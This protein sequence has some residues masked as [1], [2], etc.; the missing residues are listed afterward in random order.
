[1]LLNLDGLLLP[2][3]LSTIRSVELV[4]KFTPFPY[5][6]RDEP[7]PYTDFRSFYKFLDAVPKLFPNIRSLYLAIQGGLTVWCNQG[8]LG[9]YFMKDDVQLRLTETYIMAPIDNMLR[10]L[11]PQ[12]RDCNIAV[13]S[14]LYQRQRDQALKAGVA[15]VDRIECGAKQERYWR[16]MSSS[17]RGARAGE[18]L[19]GYWVYLGSRERVRMIVCTMAQ[20]GDP[21]GENNRAWHVF[22]TPDQLLDPH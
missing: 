19:E 12:A 5:S 21:F 17:K 6:P 11:G 2:Q 15:T 16:Q 8:G 13:S 22:H 9:S 3:R 14:T 10:K 4:W 20:G 18:Q 7:E 1:M